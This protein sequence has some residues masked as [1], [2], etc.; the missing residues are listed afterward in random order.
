ME[1]SDVRVS[2][3]DAVGAVETKLSI[4]DDKLGSD[5]IGS[6]GIPSIDDTEVTEGYNPLDTAD[7][8]PVEVMDDTAWED[9]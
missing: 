7:I 5:S 9:M 2:S 3:D 1:G 6:D 4:L 8:Q